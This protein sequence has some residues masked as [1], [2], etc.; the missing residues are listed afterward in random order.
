MPSEGDLGDYVNTKHKHGNNFYNFDHFI[1]MNSDII[2]KRFSQEPDSVE[3]C[4]DARR[5]TQ[6]SSEH[7]SNKNL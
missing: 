6:N 1:V 2:H 7:N 5:D 3:T 4:E